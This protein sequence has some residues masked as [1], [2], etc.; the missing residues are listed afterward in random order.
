MASINRDRDHHHPGGARVAVHNDPAA[1]GQFEDHLRTILENALLLDDTLR[2]GLDRDSE[3]ADTSPRAAAL[4]SSAV[5]LDQ[6]ASRTTASALGQIAHAMQGLAVLLAQL[7]SSASDPADLKDADSCP[8]QGAPLAQPRDA[9]S[10]PADL[11]DAD[12]CPIQGA[13]LAPPRG[14][15][16]IP[17]DLKD[18]DSSQTPGTPASAVHDAAAHMHA[19]PRGAVRDA[20][21]SNLEL[22]GLALLGE[23]RLSANKP[24]LTPPQGQQP[25]KPKAGDAHLAQPP[26]AE[27]SPSDYPS[28]TCSSPTIDYAL[29]PTTRS[30][31]GT[32]TTSTT[33][34]TGHGTNDPIVPQYP[35]AG[36]ADRPSST[37]P[38]LSP[39]GTARGDGSKSQEPTVPTGTSLAGTQP[40]APAATSHGN[41]LA[42]LL[43]YPRAPLVAVP[44][45]TAAAESSVGSPAMIRGQIDT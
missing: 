1:P 43:S 38:A 4:T 26:A 9:A 28:P 7:R 8:I 33:G 44:P 18:A 22:S 40:E 5:S 45:G 29:P 23:G 36:P 39:P 10:L 31:S 42:G 30:T 14:D 21:S 12:S 11:K 19:V 2:S 25:A 6:H 41:Y 13:P 3:G 24:Q 17:V 15:A 32:S 35:S 27:T 34:S 37:A 20:K 16:S